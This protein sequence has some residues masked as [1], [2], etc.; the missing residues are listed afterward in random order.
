MGEIRPGQLVCSLAGRDRGKYY[1]VWRRV[2]SRYVLVVDGRG[3]TLSSAKK[4]NLIHLQKHNFVSSAFVE[5]INSGKITDS[6]ISR[7]LKEAIAGKEE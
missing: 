5:G 7:Y 4:K 1:F 6:L 2:D 3:K